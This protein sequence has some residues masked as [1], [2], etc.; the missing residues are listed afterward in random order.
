MKLSLVAAVVLIIFGVALFFFPGANQSLFLSINSLFPNGN[1]WTAITTLGDGAVAGCIFYLL[2][3]K[4]HDV[5][6]RGLIATIIGLI[7]A[8]G[9]KKLF[10]VPR[11]EHAADFTSQF[12]QL[13]EDIAIT[14]FSMPSGHTVA[15]FLLGTLLF[16]YLKLNLASKILLGVIMVAVGVSRITLGVHWPADVFAGAGLGILIGIGCI[17]LPIHIENKWGVLI[18]HLLYLSF[19][20]SLVNKFIL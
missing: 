7:V 20:V 8:H 9:L 16:A 15:A 4:H 6:A 5:L 1:F 10:G 11:P 12:H 13:A 19:V 14:S 2:L 3:R 17:A 18:V